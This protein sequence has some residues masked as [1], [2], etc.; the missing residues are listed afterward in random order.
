MKAPINAPPGLSPQMRLQYRRI[1]ART[2]LRRVAA[3][4]NLP[5]GEGPTVH[6]YQRFGRFGVRL[7]TK[8]AGHPNQWKAALA[9]YGLRC[10]R[11]RRLI[12]RALLIA[13]LRRVAI[14]LGDPRLMPPLGMYQKLG[15]YASATVHRTLGAG[16]GWYGAALA[17]DL[18]MPIGRKL[19]HYTRGQI[20]EEYQA[21]AKLRGRQP[22]DYGPS[23]AEFYRYCGIFDQ[24]I[25]KRFG[26]W[27][28]F[29]REC[30]YVPI[31][32]GGQ[33]KEAA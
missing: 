17:A 5:D 6:Q 12:D 32:T 14:E 7:V 1:V 20:I 31:P 9:V 15:R 18:D 23:G 29:V 22:G 10:D 28:A 11:Q 19:S 27:A 24:S 16:S 30:G 21:L 4:Y 13:D 26:T 8:I 25:R 2:D 33:R 3:L